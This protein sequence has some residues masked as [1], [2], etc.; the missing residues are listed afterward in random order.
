MKE[1]PSQDAG[2]SFWFGMLGVAALSLVLGNKYIGE[3]F[4]YSN[5]A[6]FYQNGM[7]VA[8]LYLGNKAGKFSMKPFDRAQFV[9]MTVPALFMSLQIVTSFKALAIV[10]VA[11]TLV[12]RNLATCLVAG[13]EFLM[14]NS[15]TTTLT[16]VSLLVILSGAYIYAI[17][18]IHFD[19]VGYSWLLLNTIIFTANA[20]WNKKV[21]T[22]MDQTADGIALIEQA[23]SLPFLVIYAVAFG[24]LP[25][26]I[27]AIATLSYDVLTVF[28]WL[29][30][31]G[32]LIAISYSNLYKRTSATSITVASNMNKVVAVLVAWFI[33]QKN[34]LTANQV[35]GLMVCM[36]GGLWYAFESK[37]KVEPRV[38]EKVELEKDDLISSSD[39]IGDDV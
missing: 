12:F 13:V 32:T 3:S 2:T 6:L 29:G 36:G 26:G 15:R 17:D 8:M 19:P 9:Q 16:K 37:K 11:T 25:H 14:F 22:E 18:D 23:I 7:A 1:E 35:M 21:I 5:V 39:A 33:F 24:E 30:F 31:M 38:E 27:F 4:Q 28:V 10:A 20:V 34:V